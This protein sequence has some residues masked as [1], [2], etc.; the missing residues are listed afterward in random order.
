MAT[1]YGHPF[2]GATITTRFGAPNAVNG[3]PHTGTDYAYGGTSLGRPVL[4]TRA[5][6]ARRAE[7][8][9]GGHG[10]VIDHGDG[11][12]STSW[13]L[14]RQLVSDGQRVSQGQVIGLAGASGTMVTGAH[15]HQELKVNGA[16]VDPAR[17]I[18]Q[19]GVA[20]IPSGAP[21]SFPLDEGMTCPPGYAQGLVNPRAHAF[22]LSPWWNR[23]VDSGGNALACVRQGLQ[24]GDN[25]ALTDVGEGLTA[26]LGALLPILG[27]GLVILLALF[28]GWQGVRRIIGG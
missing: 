2:P 4:A 18:G 26:A 16:L 6:V 17:Y 24:P 8:L 25:T 22:P 28:I 27:N 7:N 12:E 1:L 23:P 13:H 19:A 10:V 21:D 9:G 15:L 14:S 20:S 3:A 5:G 11:T